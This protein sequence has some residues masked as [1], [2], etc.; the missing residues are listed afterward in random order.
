MNDNTRSGAEGDPL[1]KSLAGA[2][3]FLILLAVLSYFGYKLG[4]IEG[5]IEDRLAYQPPA[6]VPIATDGQPV[7]TTRQAHTIYVPVYSHIYAMGGTPVLLETTLSIRNTDPDQS[8]V[9]TSID[10]YDTKGK[11]IDEYIDGKLFLGPLESAEVL[12][13]KRDIRGGSGANFM[14]TW[15]ASTPVHQ[16]LVQAI[17]VGGEGD[18]NVS[19]RSDGQPLTYRIDTNRQD[20]LPSQQ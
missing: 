19:F 6:T 12:V 7:Y 2:A 10:Y 3:A 18:L 4:E 1:L 5:Q 16:P 13:K 8:I 9:V 17:M 15:S 14:V 11:R 20:N